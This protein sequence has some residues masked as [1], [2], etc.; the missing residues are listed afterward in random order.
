MK[1]ILHKFFM[2]MY[3]KH[4]QLPLFQRK[5]FNRLVFAAGIATPVFTLPQVFTIWYTKNAAGVSVVAW[6]AYLVIAL[7]FS[8]Y[9]ILLKE[10]PILV[11]YSSMVVLEVLIVVGAVMYG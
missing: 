7:I 4:R 6:S 5:T 8:I 3:E 11:M 10:K 9:G 1:L 2:D